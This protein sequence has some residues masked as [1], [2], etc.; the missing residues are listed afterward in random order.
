MPRAPL[1]TAKRSAIGFA[2][3]ALLLFA[4][5][6][7]AGVETVLYN[8]KGD[9][10]HDGTAPR[11]RL[12]IDATGTLFGTTEF[13][14]RGCGAP[15]CGIVFALAPASNGYS[16][17][18]IH[19][20]N[21]SNG[22]HPQGRLYADGR[23]SLFGTT[24]DGG[25]NNL[26]VVFELKNVAGQYQPHVL[27][28]FRGWRFGD[29]ANSV[30]TLGSDAKGN[31]Y[32]TTV[33]GGSGTFCDVGCGTIFKMTL[34]D[35][36]HPESVIYSFQGRA[37][38]AHPYA[39]AMVDGATGTLY[40]TTMAGGTVNA[41][42]PKGCGTVYRLAPASSGY[43]ETI[44]YRFNGGDDGAAPLATV[45]S[46]KDGNL[47]GTTSS[48]GAPCGSAQGCGTVYVLHKTARGYVERVLYRFLSN[49]DGAIPEAP[50]LRDDTTGAL[51]G[52][53]TLSNGL[54][55]RCS[56]GTAF[57]LVPGPHRYLETIFF[58]FTIPRDGAGPDAGLDRDMLGNF[59]GTT[60]HGGGSNDGTVFELTP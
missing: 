39:S 60:Y 6:S 16:E 50:L 29:G 35:V 31:L 42:C 13:G 5:A 20:F 41:Y 14:G 58:A 51:Y 57:E 48:G 30:A 2:A 19:R 23:G 53:T 56:C 59:Y 47:Y 11:G 45:I 40:G 22:S 4:H 12:L 15:G 17:T 3:I 46:D 27:H 28:S 34:K 55:G 49:D 7:A 9:A 1:V 25:A 54:G 43:A 21:G 36:Y 24:A 33:A 26:G 32:G 44:L 18:I 52:T 10:E 38:G 8:F 37:D